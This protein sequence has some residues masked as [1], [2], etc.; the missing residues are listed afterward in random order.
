MLL[1]LPDQCFLLLKTL[2][3]P[4]GEEETYRGLPHPTLGWHLAL[5]LGRSIDTMDTSKLQALPGPI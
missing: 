4:P 5:D 1:Q 3:Q 2:P